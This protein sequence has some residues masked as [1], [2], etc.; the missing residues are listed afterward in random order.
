M[1]VTTELDL[2][3][4][5]PQRQTRV[6][7]YKLRINGDIPFDSIH[8]EEKNLDGP[9]EEK[10]LDSQMPVSYCRS[11]RSYWTLAILLQTKMAT[12]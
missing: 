6:S 9:S 5:V 2:S 3:S 10:N 7:G 4:I 8:I 1:C 12:L 11:L